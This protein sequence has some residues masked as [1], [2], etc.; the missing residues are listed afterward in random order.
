[1][2]RQYLIRPVFPILAAAMVLFFTLCPTE[3]QAGAFRQ[4]GYDASTQSTA[5]SNIAYGDSLG[6]L[7][8]NPALLPR[9]GEQASI[10]IT[11]WKP[12]FHIDLAPKPVG[13]DVPLSLYAS[14]MG[15]DESLEN[16]AL[17]T[18]ELLNPRSD[19][20][21][22]D[23]YAYVGFGTAMSLDIKGFRFASLMLIPIDSLNIASTRMYYP[24]ELEQYFSNQ[25][26]FTRFGEWDKVMDGLFG[27]AYEPIKYIS[28]GAALKVGMRAVADVGIYVPDATVQDYTV[29]NNSADI[30]LALKPIIGIQSEPLEYLS[31]GLVWRHWS[32]VNMEGKTLMSL[33]QFHETNNDYIVPKSANQYFKMALDYEPMELAGGVGFRMAGFTTQVGIT[34]NIW[35]FYLDN[36]GEKPHE[37][38]HFPPSPYE[39]DPLSDDG[40]FKFKD[41]VSVTWSG[42]YQYYTSEKFSGELKVGFSYLPS[43]VPA[44]IGRT[45]YADSDT[46]GAT[47]GSR[48]DFLI[49]DQKFG[50]DIGL[51]AWFMRHREV[52][53]DQSL[54]PDEFADGITTVIGDLPMPEANGLQT[55]NPG[56]PGYSLGG[57]MILAS[58]NLRYEFKKRPNGDGCE[59]AREVDESESTP[60]VDESESAPEAMDTEGK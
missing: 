27:L 34:W 7:Y 18:I 43:P 49:A 48:F 52:W 31:I 59:S 40:R 12:N 13:S 19:T 17:P 47:L 51:Q 32:Y 5:N 14:R 54:I 3:V 4:I 53:K 25:V 28:I 44:Q 42:Q 50:V 1:M 60:E 24:T 30:K 10:G 35:H 15:S 9:F 58:I 56:F 11:F 23:P 36:H 38:A 39:D 55:N 37:A 57:Y 26:H 16:L 33:W 21:V 45:N 2:E 46:F 22:Q 8:T 6:V 29:V 41:T 20:R